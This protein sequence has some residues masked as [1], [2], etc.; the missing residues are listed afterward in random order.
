MTT[1]GMGDHM[2]G[3]LGLLN[4]Q[5]QPHWTVFLLD[6]D[7]PTQ[8]IIRLTNQVK[9]G[10]TTPLVVRING[11]FESALKTMRSA[12]VNEQSGY[13]SLH[14]IISNYDSSRTVKKLYNFLPR[15]DLARLVLPFRGYGFRAEFGSYLT[16]VVSEADYEQQQQ[17]AD[18]FFQ[19]LGRNLPYNVRIESGGETLTIQDHDAWFDLA[20]PLHEKR[21]RMLPAGEVAYTGDRINGAFVADGSLL[22][23]PEDITVVAEA[24]QLSAFS[25]ELPNQPLRLE[26]TAGKVT[27]VT[28]G[29]AAVAVQ[30]LFSKDPRYRTVTEIG[31]AFNGAC[32]HFVYDWPAASN[33]GRPGVHVGIGGDPDRREA[34]KRSDPLVHLDFIA[35]NCEAFV[36]G[37]PFLR[38][39]YKPIT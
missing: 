26:I 29:S 19:L 32:R 39:S 5:V 11:G 24:Q 33:E 20:G 28:G 34:R 18:R 30:Q 31:I 37:A 12:G 4:V 25:A 13:V 38:V 23:T 8:D 6:F 7:L 2:N 35:G 27:K 17:I 22:A 10:Q 3:Y 1:T 21:I 15:R 16:R 14:A 36:N 9:A